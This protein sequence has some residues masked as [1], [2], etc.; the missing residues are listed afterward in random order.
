VEGPQ[1][2][3]DGEGG[4]EGR[5]QPP[6][7]VRRFLEVDQGLVVAYTRRCPPKEPIRK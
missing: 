4:E 7:G 2:G 6:L 1:R 5:E 3:L